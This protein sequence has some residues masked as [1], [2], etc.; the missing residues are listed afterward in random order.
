MSAAQELLD[1]I[2][3]RERSMAGMGFSLGLALP[4]PDP[5]LKA[6][7]RDIAVYRDMQATPRI[8][9]ALRRRK[10]AVLAL[11]RGL[12]RGASKSRV[13]KNIEAMLADLDLDRI[14]GEMLAAPYFGYQPLEIQWVKVAG[15][16]V[17]ADVQSKPPEWFV[18]G[19]DNSLRFRS[20]GNMLAGE[21]LPDRKFLLARQDPTYAN[22]YGFADASMCFWSDTFIKGGQKFW[23]YFTEKYGMPFMVGKTPRGTQSKEADALADK[24]E[25]MV[26]DAVAVIPDDSSVELIAPAPGSNSADVYERLLRYCVSDINIALLGQD[27]TT[28]ANANRASATAGQEV[29]ADI[30]DA[31]ARIVAGQ[32]NQLIRWMCDLNYGG[33]DYPAYSLWEQEEVDEVQA[34]RDEKLMRAGAKLTPAYFKRAYNLEDGDLDE[35]PPPAVPGAS[36]QPAEFA[37]SATGLQKTDAIDAVVDDELRNWQE[38][39]EPMAAPLQ[40]ALDEAIAKGETAEQVLGRLTEALAQMDAQPLAD[41]LTRTAFAARLAGAAGMD[42]G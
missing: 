33:G 22:P 25:E 31:H 11:E 41:A 1:Q 39:T 35:T 40:T 32:I 29:T 14:I 37:E 36:V 19:Q 38:L 24:L 21:T 20:L 3:T 15:R 8:G 7:G 17:P 9:G 16:V 6:A 12:D 5:V 2:A 26:Q 34:G 13:A 42:L 18:F 30:R 4:N 10:S 27:Q 28:E 23:L